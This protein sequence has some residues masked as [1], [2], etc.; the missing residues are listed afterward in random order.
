M[1]L[2]PFVLI[3][4]FVASST[5]LLSGMASRICTRVRFYTVRIKPK[6]FSEKYNVEKAHISNSGIFSGAAMA[7]QMHVIYSSLSH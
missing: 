7:T 3:Y 5:V 6:S 2:G 4:I 1:F